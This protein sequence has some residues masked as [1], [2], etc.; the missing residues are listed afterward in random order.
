MR[1]SV[2]GRGCNLT[3]HNHVASAAC[4]LA[5][6]IGLGEDVIDKR[7]HYQI[8]HLDV[9]LTNHAAHVPPTHR[10]TKVAEAPQPAR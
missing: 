8:G 3:W 5:P 1:I 9:V 10:M 2:E 4:S 7:E 6:K